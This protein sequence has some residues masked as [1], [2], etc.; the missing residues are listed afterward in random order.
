MEVFMRAS[1]DID[2]SL[3]NEA[4]EIT[5]MP[6]TATVED[7]LMRFVENERQRRALRE[8]IG[9]D[10]SHHSRPTF[11]TLAAE[12]RALTADRQHTPSEI[13]LR[14]GRNER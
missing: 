4:K 2:D 3:L 11:D 1:V 13:L 14:E 6:A 7:L 12:F 5:G 8:V 10:G 9:W